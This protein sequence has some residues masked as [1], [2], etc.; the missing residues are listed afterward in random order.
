MITDDG[1]G[2]RNPAYKDS[3][4]TNKAYISREYQAAGGS[5]DPILVG[6]AIEGAIRSGE[7]TSLNSHD[8]P[9]YNRL[10]FM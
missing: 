4:K 2:R 1:R 3:F 6:A 8:P 5:T 9:L 7:N 10:V